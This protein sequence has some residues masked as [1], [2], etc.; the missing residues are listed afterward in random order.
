M[1]S[2]TSLAQ[3]SL[4][5]DLPL[6]ALDAVPTGNEAAPSH[7]DDDEKRRR[8]ALEIARELGISGDDER[9]EQQR[10]T[11]LFGKRL[12]IGGEINARLRGRRHYDLERGASDDVIDL[13]PESKLEAIWLPSDS[14]VAF[15]SIKAFGESTLYKEGGG[16]KSSAGAALNE[17]WL[18]KTGLLSTPLAAQIGRQRMQDRREWWWNENLDAVR[19]HYFGSGV[20]AFAGI[21]RNVGNL[22]TLGRIDPENR[23]LLRI[24]GNADWEWSKRQH[25]ELFALHQSDRTRRYAIGDI[26]SRDRADK[27][28]AILTWV[29]ARARGCF[30]PGFPKRICYWGDLAQVR[31]IES[32]YDLDRLTAQ[33][34][35]VDKVDR[36]KVRG[37]AYDAGVSVELPFGF[38]P[39][40]TLGH[41]RGSGD[42][43]GTPGRDGA[44]RQT[45]LHNNDGKFR[46]LS[47]FH[48]YGEVLRPDLSNIAIGTA[49]F[50]IPVG[51]HSWVETVWHRYRQPVADN[52]ISGSRINKNPAGTSDRLGKEIDVIASY[53]PSAAWQFELTGGAFR[54]GSAFGR[55]AG[56]WAALIELKIDYNF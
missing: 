24:L 9:P 27:R 45:G 7:S 32:K 37:W 19:L 36:A 1:I 18:L 33:T 38:K 26:V 15:A 56:R 13:G 2:T 42:R 21:G 51:K 6:P 14:T 3:P 17:F 8:S 29:G 44:F 16:T 31:G 11:S 43:S 10:E 5:A 49:A 52:R 22:S 23:G 30:K 20:N 41:A 48:Y 40:L 54:A 55:E 34:Q 35:I 46:G 4:A 39:V 25:I 12:I 47:R 50:G 28:D 53:R